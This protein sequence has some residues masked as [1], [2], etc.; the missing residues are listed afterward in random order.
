MSETLT[1][2]EAK[3]EK[4]LTKKDLNYTFWQYNVWVQACCSYERLQAPG[5]WC[6]MRNIIE[7]FYPEGSE[8]RAEACQRHMEFYNSEF[9]AGSLVLGLAVAMEEEKAMGA[10]IDGQAI[11]AIKTSLMGPLAGVGDTVRQG[12]FIPII[13]SIAISIGQTGNLLAPILYMVATLGL[14][15][16]ISYFLYRQAYTRGREFVAEFMVGGKMEKIM[17]MITT[18]GSIVIGALAAN[19]VKLTTTAVFAM[20]KSELNIQTDVLDT[21]L[22][23][24]LPFGAVMLVLW[25]MQKKISVNW[26]ILGIFVV[27]IIGGLIGIL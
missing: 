10:D 14:N 5:F 18:L 22:K 2:Q 3:S 15:W 24:V 4:L 20:G 26:I 16:G 27:C 8:G 23:N 12:M 7:K 9:D 13:G 6:A 17:T 21:I 19:T 11:T 1:A 25:L